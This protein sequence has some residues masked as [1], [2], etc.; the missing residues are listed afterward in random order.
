MIQ[1]KQN[2][3]DPKNNPMAKITNHGHLTISYNHWDTA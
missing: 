1:Q 3:V 2:K